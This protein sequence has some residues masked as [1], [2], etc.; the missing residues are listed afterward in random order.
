MSDEEIINEAKKVTSLTPRQCQF[1]LYWWSD[2]K[3][4]E[5]GFS[6]ARGFQEQLKM[7]IEF[8]LKIE[9]EWQGRVLNNTTSYNF[10][11]YF[12][13]F[14]KMEGI[15]LSQKFI[16]KLQGVSHEIS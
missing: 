8:Y 3:D 12:E 7:A 10:N 16:N 6:E 15:D 4:K 14:A 2:E 11:Q 13:H 9:R 5:F 1:L